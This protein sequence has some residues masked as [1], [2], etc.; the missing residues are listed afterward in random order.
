MYE[1]P[2]LIPRILRQESSVIPVFRSHSC[3]V[4]FEY[5]ED[6]EFDEHFYLSLFETKSESDVGSTVLNPEF[7]KD[8]ETI[9]ANRS[10][11]DYILKLQ[12]SIVA[13][14]IPKFLESASTTLGSSASVS[15]S[16]IPIEPPFIPTIPMQPSI[17]E[18]KSAVV[19]PPFT[20]STPQT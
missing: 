20:P 19:S 4:V 2:N 3:L 14:N 18:K 5:L 6:L 13:T 17:S 9:K 7:V 15:N 12:T 1:N 16:K 11:D 8:L 10:I